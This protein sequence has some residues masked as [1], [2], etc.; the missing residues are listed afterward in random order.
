MNSANHPIIVCAADDRYAIPLTVMLRSLA[1]NLRLYSGATVWIFDG[2]ISSRNKERIQASLPSGV[3]ELHWVRPSHRQLRGVPVTGHVSI[4]TYYRLLISDLLPSSLRKV[5]YLDVD[6]V[7][8]GDIGELWNQEL[9]SVAIGAVPE[10]GFTVA[11]PSGL[12]MYKELGLRPDAVIFNAGVLL[13]N[14]DIWRQMH[15]GSQIVTFIKRYAGQ[16]KYWDQDI[17]NGVFCNSWVA[18]DNKWNFLV[19]H[20]WQGDI[21]SLVED[22]QRVSIIHFASAF[23]PWTYNKNHPATGFYLSFVDATKWTGWRP[24]KPRLTLKAIRNNLSNKY[25][26]GRW[27]RKI[28][29][30]GP[31]WVRCAEWRKKTRRCVGNNK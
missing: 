19:N 29:I 24:T 4:C 25:W 22:K 8:L 21:T 1:Q 14:L 9:N 5:I 26:Y 27:M 3:L 7:V 23:K 10:A 2:G 16:L 11:D 20:E 12:A 15:A 30:I 13:C 18:I 6:V 28:T 31:I 17:L